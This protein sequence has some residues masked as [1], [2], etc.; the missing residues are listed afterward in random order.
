MDTPQDE[1]DRKMPAW[2]AHWSGTAPPPGTCS[3]LVLWPRHSETLG[4][5]M[6]GEGAV[7]GGRR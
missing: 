2:A 6:G 4:A 7:G 5:G 3:C 1:G